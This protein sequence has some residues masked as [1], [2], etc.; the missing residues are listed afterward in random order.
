MS[1]VEDRSVGFFKSDVW[2]F[3]LMLFSATISLLASFVL[4]VDAIELAKNP[5]AELACDINSVISCGAVASQW[6]SVLFGFPNAFI[7]LMCEPVVITIAIAGL[8]GVKF[9]RGFMAVA[10]FVYLLGLIFALWLFYQSA[11]VIHAFCPWCLLVTLGTT[12]TFFTLLRYN[13]IHNNLYLRGR[14]KEIALFSVR[15]GIDTAVEIILIIAVL[16]TIVLK[17][18]SSLLG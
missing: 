10:Q 18:G 1:I 2:L 6:Q 3:S 15:T 4:S 9:K 8:T 17:Y 13:F 7:G 16:A 11:F 12:M 14:V 5:N